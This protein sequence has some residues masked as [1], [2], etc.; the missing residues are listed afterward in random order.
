MSFA[1]VLIG[2]TPLS[3]P[4]PCAILNSII[5]LMHGDHQ[6]VYSAATVSDFRSGGKTSSFESD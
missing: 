1:N 4:S 2:V 3:L 5:S 6:P